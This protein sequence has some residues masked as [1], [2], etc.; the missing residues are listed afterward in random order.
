[1]ISAVKEF[2]SLHWE[3]KRQEVLLQGSH[4]DGRLSWG[5]ETWARLSG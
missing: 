4:S 5:A 1:M 2:L 3:K